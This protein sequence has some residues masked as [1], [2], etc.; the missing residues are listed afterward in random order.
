MDPATPGVAAQPA[1]PAPAPAVTVPNPHPAAVQPAPAGVPNPLTGQ[2]TGPITINVGQ[3]A[4]ATPGVPATV[5]LPPASATQQTVTIPLEQ[6]NAFT[7]I[8]ARLADMEARERQREDAHRT[9]LQNAMLARG[10]AEDAVRSVREQSD[11]QVRTIQDQLNQTRNQAQ[12]YAIDVEV[13]RALAGHRFVNDRARRQFEMEVR[14]ELV[15]EANGNSFAVRTP[16]FQTAEQVVAG[17]L[18]SPDYAYLLAPNGVSGTAAG[19]PTQS[20][21]SPPANAAGNL[22]PEQQYAAFVVANPNMTMGEKLELA[23]KLK[24]YGAH[25]PAPTAPQTGEGGRPIL[26]GFGLRRMS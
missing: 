2:P 1:A 26:P 18:G 16:T 13:A 24:I 10:Q 7:S 25:A 21:H 11:Q 22:A 15:A 5:P 14:S 9:E 12:N 8:Q 3:P 17:R 19:Q 23:G 20:P 4:P 6:L